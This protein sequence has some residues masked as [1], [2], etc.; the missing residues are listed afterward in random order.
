MSAKESSDDVR[1]FGLFSPM[2]YRYY[3]DVGALVP[4]LSEQAF[5]NYKV[6]VEKTLAKTLAKRGVISQNAY[7]EIESIGEIPA[8]ETY[9]EEEKTRHDIIALVNCIKRRLTSEEAKTAVHRTATSYDIVETANALRYG[10]ALYNVVIPHMV[11]LEK[12]WIDTAR[13]E[14]DTLQIGRT[15]LQHAEPITYGFANAWY[16]S[17]FGDRLLKV[18]EAV[19]RLKG[20]FSGAVG[21]YNASSLF[22]DDPE[23]FESDVMKEFGIEPFEIS[24][25]IA[26]PEPLTDMMHY[27][28]GAFTVMANWADDMRNLQRPEIAEIGQPRGENVSRSSTMPNKANPVGLENVKSM[29]KKMM[30]EMITMYMDGISDHQR[31]LTNSADQRFVPQMI[32]VFDYAVTR[33]TR[34]AKGI[35]PH[36]QNM[37]RNF[38][39]SKDKVIAEPVQLIL[40]SYGFPDAHKYIG[41]LSDKS[42][43]SNI[44]LNSIILND[45]KLAPYIERFTPRQMEILNTP[46][47]YLGIASKKAEK[48][49]DAWEKRLKDA[50]LW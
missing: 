6:D 21:A 36:T 30:P 48:V 22:F 20:K 42:V 27:I 23:T 4:Y 31:D 33:S 18:N 25:Q 29:W 32:T 28:T 40:S 46:S 15:H 41:S 5:V 37:I 16:A 39:M 47:T 34:I 8:K 45:E 35:K 24:T 49:A 11:E 3:K 38:S 7:L 12:V 50:R 1:M 19:G 44:P 17:R 43:E 13:K 14:K 9:D 2:D 26:Q 10:G